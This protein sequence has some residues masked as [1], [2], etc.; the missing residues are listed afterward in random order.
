M[1]NVSQLGKITYMFSSA[2]VKEQEMHSGRCIHCKFE[3]NVTS[4][5]RAS[6]VHEDNCPVNLA[7]HF[8]MELGSR[9]GY[10]QPN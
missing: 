4:E 5:G 6:V 9:L 2:L 1:D 8:L 7:V 10:H 3:H